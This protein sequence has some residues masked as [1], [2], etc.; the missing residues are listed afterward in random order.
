MP[1]L[2]V[3]IHTLV[4]RFLL[5]L[6]LLFGLP[7]IFL[8]MILPQRYRYKSRI[9]F[10]GVNFFYW[11]VVRASF[12]PI[13]L[14]GRDNIPDGPVI[15]AA[16][17]SSS[18]DIPLVGILTRGKPHAWLAKEDLMDWQLLKWVLP[19]LAILVNVHSR[20][21]AMRSLINLVRLVKGKNIDV[22]IFP[23]GT[24]HPDDKV[25]KFY[26]GFVTLSKMLDRPVIPVCISGANHVYPP[27]T[28]WI[29][30]YPIKVVVGKP[31]SIQEGETDDVFKGR[32]HRWFVE[33]SE[34]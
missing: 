33:Q 4:S 11:S 24:R 34:K 9:V 15:F 25:H 22:M 20:E 27:D 30:N 19:R 17:H 32:V 3:V 10:W 18:I 12:V 6:V 26:G 8:M 2:S 1:K 21:K 29:A 13:T 28:F 16:N 23:E 31:C 5:C 7:I 14:E